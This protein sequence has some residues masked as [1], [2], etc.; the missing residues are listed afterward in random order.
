MFLLASLPLGSILGI[1]IRVHWSVFVGLLIL[2]IISYP[3]YEGRTFSRFVLHLGLQIVCITAI[4]LAVLIHE[5][6][7]ALAARIWRVQTRGIYLHIF[8]GVALLSDPTAM[9]LKPRQ[10]ITVF[11]AGPASN[12]LC[13][14]LAVLLLQTLSAT[15]PIRLVAA[16]AGINL[17]MGI[18]NSL[19]IWPLDGGQLFR[20]FLSMLR[21][22]SRLSDWVTLG[23]SMLIG[24]PLAYIAWRADSYWMLS[25]L[26]ILLATA[27]LLLAVFRSEPETHAA[28]SPA[29][30]NAKGYEQAGI[31]PIRPALNEASGTSNV[32]RLFPKGKGC[33]GEESKSA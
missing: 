31:L 1:P 3:N 24:V 5:L 29:Q 14:I 21:L 8:G 10:Q 22:S 27:V 23:I 20:A 32:H 16:V 9:D 2:G 7:H 13:C 19:P 12:L 6:A 26:L 33:F 17:V 4:G 30:I 25:I 15:I 18:F 11:G 28:V